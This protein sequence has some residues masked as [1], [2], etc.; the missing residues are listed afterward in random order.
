VTVVNWVRDWLN[1]GT[2]IPELS[3]LVTESISGPSQVSITLGLETMILNLIDSY[4][5]RRYVQYTGGND[6][7]VRSDNGVCSDRISEGNIVL[8]VNS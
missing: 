6:Q 7:V 5:G 2:M 3:G 4:N 8:L 1:H